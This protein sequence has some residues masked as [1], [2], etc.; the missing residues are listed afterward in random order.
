VSPTSNNCKPTGLPA[1]RKKKYHTG[2]DW[3]VLRKV[4]VGG[5]GWVHTNILPIYVDKTF[6][7]QP[8]VRQGEAQDGSGFKDYKS[9]RHLNIGYK[10]KFEK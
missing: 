1:N 3:A 7:P 5:I 10:N 9:D 6:R 2:V 8:G 4:W